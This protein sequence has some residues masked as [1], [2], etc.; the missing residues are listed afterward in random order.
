LAALPA[1]VVVLVETAQMT[2]VLVV[3][4]EAFLGFLLEAELKGEV[5]F[6]EVLGMGGKAEVRREPLEMAMEV[7]EILWVDS[8]EVE[9]A[10]EEEEEEEEE[11]EVMNLW[12]GGRL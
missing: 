6:L 2:A 3:L 12:V 7:M 5:A 9:A 4:P 8:L 11:E 1:A 10:A